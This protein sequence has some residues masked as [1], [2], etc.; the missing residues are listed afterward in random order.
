MGVGEQE[1][2]GSTGKDPE[3]EELVVESGG[4]AWLKPWGLVFSEQ[5]D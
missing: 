3:A 2:G 1:E 5:G 4:A